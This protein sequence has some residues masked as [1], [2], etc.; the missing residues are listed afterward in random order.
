MSKCWIIG[1]KATLTNGHSYIAEPFIA[2]ETEAQA[3]AAIDMVFKVSGERPMKTEAAL[4]REGTTMGEA[5]CVVP[6]GEGK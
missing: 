3:D 1:R 2:F 6:Q 4:Y 5:I